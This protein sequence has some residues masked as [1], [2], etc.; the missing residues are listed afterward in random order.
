M[1]VGLPHT[2]YS[3]SMQI[4]RLANAVFKRYSAEHSGKTHNRLWIKM[5]RQ[6]AGVS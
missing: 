2:P 4:R 3:W 1:A 6:E 5:L